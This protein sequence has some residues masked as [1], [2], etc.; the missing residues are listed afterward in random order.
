MSFT[1][2]FLANLVRVSVRRMRRG[3]HH[4]AWGKRLEATVE[5]L[6]ADGDAKLSGTLASWR[7]SQEAAA[8]SVPMARGV[9]VSSERCAGREALVLRPAGRERGTFLYLHGG[10]YATGSPRTHRALVSRLVAATG[11]AAWVLDYRLAPEHPFPAA[12]DDA[13][14]ALLELT[15]RRGPTFV[16]GDSAGGGLALAAMCRLRD[17]AEA[18][19]PFAVLLCPWVDLGGTHPSIEENL[20]Y[21]WG[22]RRTLDFYR[23]QYGADPGHPLASPIHA[24]LTGLPPLLVQS[25]DAELLRDECRRIAD[26]ARR[27]G[28]EVEHR[29][30]PGMVHDFQLFAPFV[31]QSRAAIDEIG[32]WVRPRLDR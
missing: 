29:E 11:A 8:A 16:A 3:P 27:D 23:E 2:A 26:H 21:D 5:T 10:G 19:P 30:W 18:L 14:A 7:A 24:S 31:P 9:R 4:P 22:D 28:V 1:S 12:I 15:E 6:R 20:P 13:R 32:A 17:E 25:G